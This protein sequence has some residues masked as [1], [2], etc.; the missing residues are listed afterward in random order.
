MKNESV[1]DGP[2]TKLESSSGTGTDPF[3]IASF[4]AVGSSPM[5]PESLQYTFVQGVVG[6][7]FSHGRTWVK[8]LI[9]SIM[10]YIGRALYSLLYTMYV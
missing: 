1:R 5:G 10:F 7:S 9:I 2:A 4:R 3:V 8:A 6:P